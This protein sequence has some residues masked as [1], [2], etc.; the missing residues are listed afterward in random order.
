[1]EFLA[2][3]LLQAVFGGQLISI[4]SVGIS[5]CFWLNVI[6]CLLLI[7]CSATWLQCAFSFQFACCHILAW[8]HGHIQE[9]KTT[10]QPMQY[11]NWNS[12]KHSERERARRAVRVSIKFK[13]VL[14]DADARVS[15][16]WCSKRGFAKQDAYARFIFVGCSVA[17]G[18]TFRK[19]LQ[20]CGAF[21]NWSNTWDIYCLWPLALIPSLSIHYQH[22]RNRY[23]SFHSTGN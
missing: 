20:C 9:R 11:L 4:P 6:K 8:R 21:E 3:T 2:I 5:A 22:V 19:P 17:G 10:I 18:Q 14:E 1:M 23:C 12:A 16:S 7:L 15:A 13:Q